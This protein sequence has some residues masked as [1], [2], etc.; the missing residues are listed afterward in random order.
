MSNKRQRLSS[1]TSRNEP[2]LEIVYVEAHEVDLIYDNDSLANKVE[3]KG[4]EVEGGRLLNWKNG[5]EGEIWID[6]YVIE[7]QCL[8]FIFFSF[9]VVI[10][11]GGF[12][13]TIY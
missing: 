7:Q 9:V 13:D 5:I 12:L 3:S 10:I 11:S 8:L 1:P 2:E 4:T 6:R